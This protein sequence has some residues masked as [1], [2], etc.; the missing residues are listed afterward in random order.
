MGRERQSRQ[1]ISKEKMTVN[2][3][4]EAKP[5]KNRISAQPSLEGIVKME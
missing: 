1:V 2:K 3:I 4:M 5:G